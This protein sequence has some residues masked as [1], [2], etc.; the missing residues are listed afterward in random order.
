MIKIGLIGYGYWGTNLLRNFFAVKKCS[1][2][3]VCDFRKK[4]LELAKKLF[5]SIKTTCHDKEIINDKEIQAIVIAT[6]VSLHYSLAKKGLLADKPF[7]A[8]E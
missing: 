3:K 6:P 1:V 7:F 2:V 5:P 4:R 8:N